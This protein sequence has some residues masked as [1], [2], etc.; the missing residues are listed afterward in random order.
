MLATLGYQTR[1]W[2]GAAASLVVIGRN[3]LKNDESLAARLERH[4]WAGGRA[5]I[6][7]QDPEWMTKA[8]GWRVCPKVARR[9]FAVNSPF[10]RDID[11]ADL[12]DWTGSSTLIEAYPEYVGNYLR[13]NEREQPYAGWHW[14][15]RG[16]VTSAAIEK[17]HRSGWRPLLECEFDL[18][19]SPLLE[20][21]YGQGRVIV[22]TL[23]LEDHVGLDPAAQLIAGHIIDY[24]L[25][26][27]LSPR[28]SDVVYVGG[29]AGAAWLDKIGVNYQQ[30]PTVPRAAGTAGAGLLL[31]GPDAPLDTAAL[32]VY[33][34]GGGKA[35]FLPCSQADGGLGA[36]L[37]PAAADF[38][39]S[40]SVPDW[41]ETRG[42]SASD[43]RW[44]TSLEPAPWVVSAGAE[45]GADGLIGR[46][47]IGKGVAIFC[48]IDPD[49][50]QADQ[51]TYFRYT[52]WRATRAVAQLLANLGASFPA[53]N[54]IFHP[55]DTMMLSLDGVWQ[56]QVTLRLAPAPND[57][58]AHPDPGVTLPAQRLIGENVPTEGWTP[59]TL[60]QMLPFFKDHDGEA[61]FRKEI[62]VPE[63]AVGKDMVLT[64]G[65]LDDFDNTYFNGVEIGHTNAGTAT[66]WLTPRNYVVPGK[67][68]KAGRN[69]VAVRLFDRFSE[70][71]F[72]GN[73]GPPDPLA[74]RP[75]PQATGVGE[76]RMFLRPKSEWVGSA[77]YYCADYRTDFPMGDNPYRYYRW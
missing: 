66:W 63:S 9:V 61:L 50:F 1:S 4:V 75:G 53:D 71:G 21:D 46:K 23:D 5:L 26:C 49:R 55:L 47:V 16:G 62:V 7:A 20:L 10:V 77:G 36:K 54:R 69:V 2:S 48:Q 52:R 76:L 11:A 13:G 43:L 25:H 41:P 28:V 70:G 38:A 18:A 12:R 60:P 31:I 59:V 39:G 67:L 8:L 24:A 64:L 30:S 6:C 74:D 32:T 17:P 19:Y 34:E 65:G 56:A 37:K 35:F 51:K 33:I 3:A 27:T 14:G 72:V 15:N 45:V 73:G 22:C 29:P 57:A 42:L 44:R 68:I 40:L 58:A